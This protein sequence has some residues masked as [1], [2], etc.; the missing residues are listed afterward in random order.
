MALLRNPRLLLPILQGPTILNPHVAPTAGIERN[1]TRVFKTRLRA[2]P[3][4]LH[5]I[6]NPVSSGAGPARGR[7]GPASLKLGVLA[8]GQRPGIRLVE[9]QLAPV[10]NFPI[11]VPG[12]LGDLFQQVRTAIPSP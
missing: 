3:R 9:E 11:H 12:L 1:R 6:H 7:R 4:L 8:I 10:I 2:L 5:H